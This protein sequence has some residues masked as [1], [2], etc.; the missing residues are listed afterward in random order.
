MELQVPYF[1]RFSYSSI[2]TIIKIKF[3]ISSL[4]SSLVC[5]LFI[6]SASLF[7]YILWFSHSFL[8]SLQTGTLSK[9]GPNEFNTTCLLVCFYHICHL[10]SRP[11]NPVRDHLPPLFMKLNCLWYN[12]FM[13]TSRFT[14]LFLCD[15]DGVFHGNHVFWLRNCFIGFDDRFLCQYRL[16]P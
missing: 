4:F 11:R 13:I 14:I 6:K 15:D 16:C 12:I 8:S 2:V 3:L 9:E 7:V 5:N 1:G 10:I